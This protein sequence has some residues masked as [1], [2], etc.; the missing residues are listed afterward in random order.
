VKKEQKRKSEGKDHNGGMI[1]EELNEV[2][3]HAKKTGKAVD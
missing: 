2:L 3:K 1:I